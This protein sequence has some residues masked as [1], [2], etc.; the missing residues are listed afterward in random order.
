MAKLPKDHDEYLAALPDPQRKALQKLRATIRSAAPDAEECISYRLAAFRQDGMLVAYGATGKHCAFFPMNAT[1][2]AA[3][4]AALAGWSTS[5]GT[6]RFQPETP[7]PAAL[8]RRIVKERLA[9][10]AASRG[11]TR[12]TGAVD[13]FLAELD[14]PLKAEFA[15]VRTQILAAAPGI[16][17]GIKWNAPSFRTSDWFATLFLRATDR[18]QLILHFGAKAKD[19]TKCFVSIEDPEGMIEWLATDRAMVTVGT[20]K[21]LARR[22]KALQ[23]LVRAWIAHLPPA[24][25]GK[26]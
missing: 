3:H 13:A 12:D 5:K 11:A 6:I 4:A 16:E 25:D 19:G 17:D 9:E 18:V 23:D 7:L 20:G 22:R 21:Q 10:N 1:S 8:V 26:A 14:H 15:V 24:K 2:V